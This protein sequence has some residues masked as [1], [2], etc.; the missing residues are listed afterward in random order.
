M[1]EYC[2][3]QTFDQQPPFKI[4]WY[5]LPEESLNECL[6]FLRRLM[7]DSTTPLR[8]SFMVWIGEMHRIELKH[9]ANLI[10]YVEKQ[11]VEF[12]IHRVALPEML[13][14]PI[15]KEY[16]QKIDNINTMLA[17]FNHD[18]GYSRYALFKVGT[19]MRKGGAIKTR[20]SDWKAGTSLIDTSKVCQVI[21][22][23]HETNFPPLPLSSVETASSRHNQNEE[24]EH[25]END[26]QKKADWL[27]VGQEKGYLEEVKEDWQGEQESQQKS[28]KRRKRVLKELRRAKRRKALAKQPKVRLPSPV[29]TAREDTLGE[30]RPFEDETLLELTDSERNTPDPRDVTKWTNVIEIESSETSDQDQ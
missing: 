25:R 21:R 18:H 10:K 17:Q 24:E 4:K 15:F 9:V 12:P 2:W 13:F 23:F 30:E 6:K 29:K 27:Q 22:W 3:K 20:A 19:R 11:L 16:Y 1:I 14:S 8:I 26:D 7:K 28:S 5:Y